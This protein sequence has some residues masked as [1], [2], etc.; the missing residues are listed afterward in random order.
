MKL[1]KKEIAFLIFLMNRQNPIDRTRDII[2]QK[3]CLKYIKSA[4]IE[5][6]YIERKLI[7]KLMKEI[8]KK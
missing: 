3:Y 4:L 5:M 1:T 8:T 6:P 2:I 7:R